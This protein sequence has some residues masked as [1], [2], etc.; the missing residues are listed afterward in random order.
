MYISKL[1]VRNY[2]NF[3]NVSLDF[4]KG[5][6]TIIG[7]NGSGKTNILHALRLLIDE[8]LP[9]NIK[10]YES[11][12]NR[13][14]G[15][16]KGHWIIIQ[17]EFSDLDPSEEA[18]AIAMHKAGDMEDYDSTKGTYSLI[19]RPRENKRRE[20]FECSED[21]LPT[22]ADL[23][24]ILDSIT[25][26]D[27]ELTFRG[28]GNVDFSIDDNYIKYVGDFENIVFPNPEDQQEDIYGT[29]LIGFSIPNELSCTFIKALRD[30]EA[31]LRSYRDNPL[32]SLLR[33]KEQ[34]ISVAKKDSIEDKV[35]KLN[36]EISD[37]DE[38]KDVSQG[39]SKSVKQ[40]VGETYA[41]N[42]EI[43]SEVP[44]EIEKLLQSL[45]LWVGDSDE[46]DYKG[47][48]WELS[49]GGANLIYFSLKLLE[50]EK[51]KAQNK[52]ANFL[53]IEEP[54][55]HIHTHIQKTL[56]QKLHSHNTQIIISTHSTHIS[57]VSKIS[58]VN[59]LSRAKK[60]V[61]VFSPANGLNPKQIR[62]LERYLDAVRTN[63]L[64]AKGVALVEGDAEHI[65]IPALFK[66]VFGVSLDEIGVSLINIGSTG[67]ENIAVIFSEERIKKNC[68]I[69]TDLD[70][71]ILKL[72]NDESEDTLE[73]RGC[74]NSEKSG[75]LRKKSLED[76][77]SKN[78]WVS[79]FYGEHT[80]EVEFIR[81]DNS[82]EIKEL[83]KAKYLKEADQKRIS[84]LLEDKKVEVYGK[85]VLRLADNFGKGWF[86]LM[87]EEHIDHLT[88][89]PDYILKAIAFAS[90]HINQQTLLGMVKFRLLSLNK[91]AY[92]GDKF[93]YQDALEQ[94]VNEEN[95]SN[96]INFFKGQL[97]DDQLTLFINYLMP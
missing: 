63:L 74:R 6:N 43:K 67:F 44:S 76:F 19:F 31:D 47:R 30:V 13:S 91:Q 60:E 92:D 78:P 85:E 52:I 33:G 12:F 34:S 10:F 25:L 40:A 1:S 96:A 53:L 5:V 93:D 61:L 79:P 95:P 48:I 88:S 38:V 8:S 4:L 68:A 27:Y 24:S 23:Q 90:P 37:L 51:V 39:I 86:A 59:I 58:S 56:F 54:E 49:L 62:A 9:R 3:R 17:I 50:Y 16:W 89:I 2:R 46:P 11:D 55:A 64:F 28:R 36:E 81:A 42:I 82:F 14:I 15:D 41:P 77:C 20:L 69:I 87:L 71:S 73:E 75:I 94:I 66:K 29:R 21:F 65:L 70:K 84:A 80:F 35:N 97:P 26:N 7:E 72:A 32:L 57:S 83:V 18:Q 45:K 22:Q